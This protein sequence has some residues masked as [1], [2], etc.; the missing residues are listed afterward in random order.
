MNN[1]KNRKEAKD[2]TLDSYY[3]GTLV[4]NSLAGAYPGL[5]FQF[6][7]V[8]AFKVDE[9]HARYVGGAAENL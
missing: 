4:R 8:L 1:V 3:L 5:P 2:G 6:P 9:M 7:S